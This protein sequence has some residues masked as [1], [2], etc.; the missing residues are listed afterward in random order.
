VLLTIVPIML[1]LISTKTQAALL[2]YAFSL[3]LP[4]AQGQTIP[5]ISATYGSAPAPFKLDV[6][7][8]FIATTVQKVKS[9]RIAND[10]GV[11]NL[12]DGPSTA[13]ATSV[14]NFWVHDF[15]WWAIQEQFNQK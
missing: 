4:F 6:H 8:S 10:I 7:S 13:T 11:P 3:I 1:S 12:V 9:S 5:E 2:S 14:K 15:D